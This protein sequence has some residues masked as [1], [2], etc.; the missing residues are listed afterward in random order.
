MIRGLCN[1]KDFK[2]VTRSLKAMTIYSI[3]LLFYMLTFDYDISAILFEKD[4][5]HRLNFTKFVISRS[6][7]VEIETSLALFPKNNFG[8]HLDFF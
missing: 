8:S 1:K 2:D 4:A 7:L 3:T 6:I 5:S